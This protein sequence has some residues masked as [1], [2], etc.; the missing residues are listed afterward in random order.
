M[1]D[2]KFEQCPHSERLKV[3]DT[4]KNNCESCSIRKW[5]DPTWSFLDSM[6]FK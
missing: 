1:E 3:L 6:I 5:T 4:C 2:Q